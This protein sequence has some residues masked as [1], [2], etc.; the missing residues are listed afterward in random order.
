MRLKTINSLGIIV[1]LLLFCA[2]SNNDDDSKKGNISNSIVGTWAVKNMSCLDT[3]KLRAD[4]LTFT[5]NKR[6]EAKHYVD[7][8]GYGIFKYDDTYT[9]SWSVDGNKISMQMPSLWIGPN[10]LVIE[11]V[12]ENNI[13]FSPWGNKDAYATMEKY[14]EPVNSIYGYW[15]FSK[16]TGTL[17]K[18]DGTVLDIKDGSFTFH[19]L[20]FSKTELRNYKGYNGVILDRS[21]KSPQLIN[22]DFDGWMGIS[23]LKV[24]HQI[25]PFCISMVMMHQMKSLT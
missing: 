4:I 14:T 15:E 13:S 12:Q 1:L 6:I 20:Y 2:C 21:E 5:A 22:Y 11:D 17:T 10:N 19:Y 25:M 8:T 23:W 16:Y 18:A 3:E 7:K 24:Y 9:G